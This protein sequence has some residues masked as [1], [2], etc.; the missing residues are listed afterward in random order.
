MI[1]PIS[2]AMPGEAE[3]LTR[4]RVPSVRE[5]SPE[6]CAL[7]ASGGPSVGMLPPK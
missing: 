4:T 2:T 6:G 3:R 7:N 5:G 1:M